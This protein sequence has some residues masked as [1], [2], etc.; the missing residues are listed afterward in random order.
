MDIEPNIPEAP[1][2]DASTWSQDS[3]FKFIDYR[4]RWEGKLRRTDL[5]DFFSI[6]LPQASADLAKYDRAAPENLKYDLSQKCY[7]RGPE[8]KATYARSSPQMYLSELVALSTGVL[9]RSATFLGWTPPVGI[10]PAPVRSF[11]ADVLTTL[12]SA[13]KEQLSTVIEYQSMESVLPSSLEVS[14]TALAYDGARW[15]V[16]AYC[17]YES[18]FRDFVLGRVLNAR[19][20]DKTPWTAEQDSAWNTL[21]LLQIAPNPALTEAGRKAAELEFGMLEGLLRIEVRQALLFHT[22]RRMRLE[23]TDAGKASQPNRLV[24]VNREEIELYMQN[25]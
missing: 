8:F 20:K 9:E 11:D 10:A 13:I 1:Q 25:S 23:A 5:T 17:H 24:L 19:A 15:H 7:I 6:S 4:L 22:L 14:P 3:R 21:V 2:P 12:L 18:R 16:R